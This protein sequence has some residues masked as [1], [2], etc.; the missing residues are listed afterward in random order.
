MQHPPASFMKRLRRARA[1]LFWQARCNSGSLYGMF[2]S[3]NF[4][5]LVKDLLV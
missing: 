3:F 4:T 1:H 5:A 2:I